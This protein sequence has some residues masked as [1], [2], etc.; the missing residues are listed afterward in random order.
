MLVTEEQI[1]Q[2]HEDGAIL[3][4]N[5]FRKIALILPNNKILE[6]T[7]NGFKIWIFDTMNQFTFKS[8]LGEFS[9]RWN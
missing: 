5:A 4:K 3:L 6:Y 2:F 7:M 9:K 8:K 1:N